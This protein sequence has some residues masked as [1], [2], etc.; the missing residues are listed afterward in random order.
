VTRRVEWELSNRRTAVAEIWIE[1]WGDKFE[2]AARQRVLVVATGP[3]ESGHLE[4]SLTEGTLTLWAWS[5]ASI[6]VWDGGANR[7]LN[8]WGPLPFLPT[9]AIG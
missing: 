4:V 5:G 9:P 1:P 7:L 3:A 2:L 8:K 6:E